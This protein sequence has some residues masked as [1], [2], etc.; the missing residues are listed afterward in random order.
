MMLQGVHDCFLSAML[1]KESI[2]MTWVENKNIQKIKRY[3]QSGFENVSFKNICF[4]EVPHN[5]Y[6]S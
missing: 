1:Q 2:M 6:Q 4:L 3:L 5:L